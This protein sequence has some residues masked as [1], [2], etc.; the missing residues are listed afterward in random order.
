MMEAVKVSPGRVQLKIPEH[1]FYSLEQG[2]RHL[3]LTA[4]LRGASALSQLASLEADDANRCA[5]LDSSLTACCLDHVKNRTIGLFWRFEKLEE[6]QT[7]VISLR[8]S[9]LVDLASFSAF[10]AHLQRSSCRSSTCEA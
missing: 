7:E 2:C 4:S 6:L 3:N 1:V 5:C 10:Y 9:Y 8:I